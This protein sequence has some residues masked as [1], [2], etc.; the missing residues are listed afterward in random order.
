MLFF[1]RSL[2][3]VLIKKIIIVR[4]KFDCDKNMQDASTLHLNYTWTYH[5]VKVIVELPLHTNLYTSCY[6]YLNW[7]P[8]HPCG[9]TSTLLV[10][11]VK[12]WFVEELFKF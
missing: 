8:L 4:K 9:G 3:I 12:N 7:K 5:F 11:L 1:L 10:I 6:Q 2:K